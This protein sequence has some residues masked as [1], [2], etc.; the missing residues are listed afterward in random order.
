MRGAPDR[1][2]ETADVRDKFAAN[3]GLRYRPEEVAE[4]ALEIL[5]IGSAADTGRLSNLLCA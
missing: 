2:V 5:E 1:P 4:L 3:A